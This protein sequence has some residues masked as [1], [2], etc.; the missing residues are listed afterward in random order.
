MNLMDRKEIER[1][2]VREA[3]TR[4]VIKRIPKM[5]GNLFWSCDE[6]RETETSCYNS[7]DGRKTQQMET[8][9]KMLDGLTK[10]LKVR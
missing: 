1:N 5:S 6:K 2:S 10:W 7:N 3:D 8:T 4:P 9:E